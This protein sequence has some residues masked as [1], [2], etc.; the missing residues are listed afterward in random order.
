MFAQDRFFLTYALLTAFVLAACA[1]AAPTQNAP[2]GQNP[3][4]A[5]E[6][7]IDGGGESAV[8]AQI[9]ACA[10]LTQ[11]DAEGVLSAQTGPALPGDAPPLYSCSYQTENFDVVQVVVLVYENQAQAQAAYQLA[12]TTNGYTEIPGLGDRA[13][14]AQPIFDVNVL[15]GNLEVT[16]DISDSTDDATQLQNSIE[17][18]ELVISRL[19]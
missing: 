16:V 4:L 12:I 2:E 18:A 9:D 7:S 3:V 11:A 5:T 10:L 1:P 19:N 6:A 14:N 13:Y 17:L 15:V 8:S